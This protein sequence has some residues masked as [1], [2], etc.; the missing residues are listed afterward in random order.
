MDFFLRL[1]GT[2]HF[3]ALPHV[4]PW[5]IS[6]LT[7]RCWHSRLVQR[8]PGRVELK[9]PKMMNFNIRLY[10]TDY[11]THLMMYHDH[12]WS[13]TS[14]SV[15]FWGNATFFEKNSGKLDLFKAG[16]ATFLQWFPCWTF[17]MVTS[18]VVFYSTIYIC[19][20]SFQQLEYVLLIF[21]YMV[22]F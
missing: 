11:Q 9:T 17:T 5:L 1:E 15:F 7:T 4:W 19:I 2:H 12:S 21:T 13:K 10:Q 8:K 20:V 16:S 3:Q 6:R 14:S 18:M 22:L